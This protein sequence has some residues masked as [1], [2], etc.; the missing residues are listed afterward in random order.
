MTHS[1]T[2]HFL[3]A[4]LRQGKETST[5][6]SSLFPLLSFLWMRP[7][8]VASHYA[9]KPCERFQ[10]KDYAADDADALPYDPFANFEFPWRYSWQLLCTLTSPYLKGYVDLLCCLRTFSFAKGI[11]SALQSQNT[12]DVLLSAEKPQPTNEWEK[13]MAKCPSFLA[14]YRTILRHVLHSSKKD[15]QRDSAPVVHADHSFSSV[16]F[17]GFHPFPVMA[18]HDLTP[19]IPWDHPTSK[20]TVP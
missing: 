11:C 17:T 13:S 2:S 10:S 4:S 5:P 16:H 12:K 19:Y 14:L 9:K 7:H 3:P 1:S 8:Y 18:F 6:E 20:L 15:S